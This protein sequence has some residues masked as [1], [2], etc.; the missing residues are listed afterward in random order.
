MS[1]DGESGEA[2]KL[3]GWGDS[4]SRLSGGNRLDLRKSDCWSTLEQTLG[5]TLNVRAVCTYDWN[6]Y[7]NIKLYVKE[8]FTSKKI[9]KKIPLLLKFRAGSFYNEENT[10][11]TS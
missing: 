8:I 7:V 6:F 9:N 4:E 10:I 1:S 5:G 11:K 3:A 2:A